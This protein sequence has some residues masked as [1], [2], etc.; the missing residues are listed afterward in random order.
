MLRGLRPSLARLSSTTINGSDTFA[1]LSLPTHAICFT[2]FKQNSLV[3]SY[4]S[5]RGSKEQFYY[6]F[7]LDGALIGTTVAVIAGYMSTSV[8]MEYFYPGSNSPINCDSAKSVQ[9]QSTTQKDVAKSIP[10]KMEKLVNKIQSDMVSALEEIEGPD[11]GKFL[12]DSWIREEGGYGTSCVLQ[13][14]RVF[15][16]AGVNITIIASPAPKAMIANMRARNKDSIDPN[17]NYKMFVAGVS[18]VVHPHNPMA[19]TFHANY[20]YFELR[21][22]SSNA[23]D[24]DKPVAAWFGGGCDLTPSY[25]FE[26]DAVHFHK[27]IK[28]TCN[29]HDPEYYPRFKEWCDKYFNNVHRGERRGIGGIFFDDLE[30]K[31]AD[32]LFSFVSDCGNSLVEQYI[33]IVKRR[34]NMPFT[35]AQKEWQQ[36][37]R[38]RY[39]E[40]NL[41][42]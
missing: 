20:R 38:G 19:P 13:E 6:T 11:G 35:P 36:L 25:L 29:K 15:E 33:P 10:F 2:R 24:S 37:R 28:D 32:Q 14:G 12:H 39:V 41:V 18:M 9:K 17:G 4:S 34:I 27:V 5:S 21:D 8:L 26:E 30:D 31:P 7:N 40:F 42:I 22:A 23:K 1:R 3:C 16:K